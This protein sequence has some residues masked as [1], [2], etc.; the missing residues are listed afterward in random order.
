MCHLLRLIRQFL[1]GYKPATLNSRR[2]EPVSVA[3]GEET[4]IGSLKYH[5]LQFCDIC[6]VGGVKRT[7]G[8]IA[9]NNVDESAKVP[10]A[11]GSLIELKVT[12]S[13]LNAV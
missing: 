1:A 11:E 13:E 6:D 2:K 10:H 3:V 4:A 5:Y 9:E 12:T 7:S 8:K